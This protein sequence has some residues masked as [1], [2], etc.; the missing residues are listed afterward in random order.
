MRFAPGHGNAQADTA[1]QQNKPQKK[2]AVS[3]RT[4][5]LF[6]VHEAAV[7]LAFDSHW[8]VRTLAWRGE[9]PYVQLSPRRIAFDVDDLDRF[10]EARKI[11]EHVH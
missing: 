7:Y 9:L 10:I 4:K 5:R 11:R 6:T 2:A 3:T 1:T 8:P